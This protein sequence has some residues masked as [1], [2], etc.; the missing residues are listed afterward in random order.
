MAVGQR[1]KHVVESQQFSRL[2]LDEIMTRASEMER[3]PHR[4]AVPA[5]GSRE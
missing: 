4:A 1:L 3:E 5:S 2:L